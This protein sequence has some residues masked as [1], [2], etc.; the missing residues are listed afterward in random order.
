MPR[1]IAGL[2]GGRDVPT[3]EA[4]ERTAARKAGN[5]VTGPREGWKAN[6]DAV[7]LLLHGLGYP[8]TAPTV[9][10]EHVS[11]LHKENLE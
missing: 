5:H 4:R 6:K 9:K 1:N 10:P 2:S 8:A 7:D 3:R 11:K